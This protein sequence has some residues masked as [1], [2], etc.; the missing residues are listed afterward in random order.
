MGAWEYIRPLIDEE[1]GGYMHV[2]YVGRARSA[3]PAAGSYALHKKQLAQFL[4]E[5]FR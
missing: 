1:L 5:A 4:E 2:Q 3:A